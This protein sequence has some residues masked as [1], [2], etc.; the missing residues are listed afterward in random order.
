MMRRRA[1]G[2]GVGSIGGSGNAC[3]VAVVVV[4]YEEGR[5]ELLRKKERNQEA[6]NRLLQTM[7]LLVRHAHTAV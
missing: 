3:R 1:G 2:T 6:S 4:G 7:L 5:R